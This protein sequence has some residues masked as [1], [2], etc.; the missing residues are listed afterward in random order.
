MSVPTLKTR[1]PS[2]KPPQPLILLA[3][4]EKTGKTYAGAALSASDVV[5][6]TFWIEIGEGAADQYGEL[7]GAR[8]EIVEHD[9][10]YQGIGAAIYAA[11]QQPRPNGKPHAIVIDSMTELWDLLADEAQAVANERAA[12]RRG[13]KPSDSDAQITMD[14]WN[15]AKKRWRRIVDTVR[16]YDG[17]VILTARLELV[18]VMDDGGKPTTAK[19]WKIRA[20]KNLPFECDA[21][22]RMPAPGVAELTGVRS[23]RVQ[24]PAGGALPLP[25]FTLERL[26]TDLGVTE[27]GATAVRSYTAPR[28]VPADAEAD[29]DR[30]G[31]RHQPA[32]PVED[33]WSAP[34]PAASSGPAAPPAMPSDG[35]LAN[36]A[37]Q[38]KE[39]HITDADRLR[40]TGQLLSREVPSFSTLT[41]D[42]YRMLKSALRGGWPYINHVPQV[43]PDVPEEFED[44]PVRDI[45]VANIAAANSPATMDEAGREVAAELARGSITPAEAEYVR[46]VWTARKAQLQAGPPAPAAAPPQAAGPA[47][48]GSPDN[49][50]IADYQRRMLDGVAARQQH[51]PAA[52]VGLAQKYIRSEIT[53]LSQL[54]K[55]EADTLLHAL[56]TGEKPAMAGAA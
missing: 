50:G 35:Q 27:Q 54:S 17:P 30:P 20:E 34:V 3:G 29:T 19:D 25:G 53:D 21:I 56:T 33:E 36:L 4:A 10:T 46:A 38:F 48:V 51:T 16:T 24:V 47:P 40:C 22:V 28:A 8:Y 32:E 12:R 11:T 2:G 18:T 43:L 13:N 23:L 44:N 39:R 41:L 37:I 9:G 52:L 5:D 55:A 31:R 1:R 6:R 26:L 49:P 14:L 7:P 42:E 45:L 15:A